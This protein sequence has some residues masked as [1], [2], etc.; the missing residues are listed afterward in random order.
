MFIWGLVKGCKSWLSLMFV[1]G[2][3]IGCKILTEFLRFIWKFVGYKGGTVK[4]WGKIVSFSFFL[5]GLWF[6]LGCFFCFSRMLKE[7]KD[8]TSHLFLGITGDF[9]WLV[10]LSVSIPRKIYWVWLGDAS[11]LWYIS[12]NLLW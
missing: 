1:W 2:L 6:V 4:I 12:S 8:L 5:W 9:V 3:I 7:F 10:S 11:F